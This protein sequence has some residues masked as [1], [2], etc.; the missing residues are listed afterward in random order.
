MNPPSLN[1]PL[2]PNLFEIP[3]RLILRIE[4]AANLSPLPQ[5]DSINPSDSKIEMICEEKLPVI[6]STTGSA[7]VLAHIAHD[8]YGDY[9]YEFRT[10]GNENRQRLL[11]LEGRARNMML[12]AGSL[13]REYNPEFERTDLYINRAGHVFLTSESLK[14]IP[15]PDHPASS[16]VSELMKIFSGHST[17]PKEIVNETPEPIPGRFM[18]IPNDHRIVQLNAL[19]RTIRRRHREDKKT[20]D[21]TYEKDCVSF[22]V[23]AYVCLNDIIRELIIHTG[24]VPQNADIFSLDFNDGYISGTLVEPDDDSTSV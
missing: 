18:I 5:F 19:M 23:R 21:G 22:S 20:S 11:M 15:K 14:W 16:W 3:R 2:F 17:L 1:T 4:A 9:C 24:Q 10:N 7:V 13:A 6:G 12:L 8:Y